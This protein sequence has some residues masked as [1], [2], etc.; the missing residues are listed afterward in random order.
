[1][2]IPYGHQHIDD[3]DVAAVVEALRSDWLTQGPSLERFEADLV[4]A[5][6]AEHAVAFSSGTAALHAAAATAGLGAGDTLF[7][8]PLSFAASATCARYVGATPAFVDID[9]AT[10]NIDLARVP[11][12]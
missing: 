11:E 10:L 7:T 4:G 5:T 2:L 12:N 8:S 3:D 1:M 6:G 9:T